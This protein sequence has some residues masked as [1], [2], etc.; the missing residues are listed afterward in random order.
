MARR[1]ST[2]VESGKRDESSRR[3]RGPR[4]EKARGQSQRAQ[5]ID[6]TS[7]CAARCSRRCKREKESENRGTKGRVRVECVS[8]L[9]RVNRV[10]CVRNAYLDT[11]HTT[12]DADI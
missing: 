2:A 1:E 7:R 3:R 4:R 6:V 9:T 8:L 10:V 12:H 11:T 5:R